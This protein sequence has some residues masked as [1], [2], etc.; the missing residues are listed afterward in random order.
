MPET[1]RK[2]E[3]MEA[4]IEQL[5]RELCNAL[6]ALKWT[7]D[8]LVESQAELRKLKWLI[9]GLEEGAKGATNTG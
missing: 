1:E 7:R 3:E 2:E 4:K 8:R 6:N 5:N 9:V